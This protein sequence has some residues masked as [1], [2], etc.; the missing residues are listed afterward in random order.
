MLTVA[1]CLRRAP[2]PVEPEQRV[3]DAVRLMRLHRLCGL[4]VVKGETLIGMILTET[5][6]GVDTRQRIV[7]VMETEWKAVAPTDSVRHV[8]DLMIREDLNCV[9]VVDVEGRI[10][11]VLSATEIMAELRRTGDP[12]TELPWSDILREWATSALRAGREITL[13]FLD[14]DDFGLFN[15]HY[16]HVVGDSVLRS[17]ADVLRGAV[18]PAFE[19]VCRYGGDEFCI[20]TLRRR[21][22][23]GK[24]AR[25]IKQEIGNIVPV[26]L[27][28]ER[29][30]VSI[31]ASGGKRTREREQIHY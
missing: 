30:S 18:D 27:P 22:D 3:E 20:A 26:D 1:E 19:I 7:E 12:L 14:I 8:A 2:M 23:A 11:G 6:L 24:L 31:G 5:L 21:S 29:I 16:G 10:A 4:P 13:L 9:P 17:V 25:R 15:K 28:N